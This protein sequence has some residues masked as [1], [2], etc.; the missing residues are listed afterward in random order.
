MR[1]ATSIQDEITQLKN[2]INLE[3]S[4]QISTLKETNKQER[5]V[6]KSI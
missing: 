2:E 3:R 5:I 1:N 4:R 6:R